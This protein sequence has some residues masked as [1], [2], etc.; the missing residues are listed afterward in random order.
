MAVLAHN[1]ATV[2]GPGHDERAA[3]TRDLKE[4]TG[5]LNQARK[6]WMTFEVATVAQI[7]IEHGY[8]GDDVLLIAAEKNTGAAFAE[9]I[10][11]SGKRR[12]GVFHEVPAEWTDGLAAFTADDLADRLG[13]VRQTGKYHRGVEIGEALE[14][15]RALRGPDWSS[16]TGIFVDRR[17]AARQAAHEA[18][19][20]AA[21]AAAHLTMLDI[22]DA[23][24]HAKAARFV[25]DADRGMLALSDV[26]DDDGNP[27]V[28]RDVAGFV[29]TYDNGHLTDYIDPEAINL[30]AGDLID[31]GVAYEAAGG[32][33]IVPFD[34]VRRLRGVAD[35]PNQ[36][37][38]FGDDSPHDYGWSGRAAA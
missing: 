30:T 35:D 34:A 17:A 36:P 27:I 14:A 12:G 25:L 26:L 21:R 8:K 5:A 4:A 23:V 22:L 29:D 2:A 10:V 3:A 7:A 1:L 16:S 38:L 15:E 37:S 24:P 9:Y 28:D 31:A 18:R 11:L 19:D 33:V 32:G 20:K 13:F 6:R